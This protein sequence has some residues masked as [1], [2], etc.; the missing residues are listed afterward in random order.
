MVKTAGSTTYWYDADDPM[1]VTARVES[2]LFDAFLLIVSVGL[3]SAWAL[4][5]AGKPRFAQ[6]QWRSILY[7]GGLIAASLAMACFGGFLMHSRLLGG[8]GNNFRP[9]IIWVRIG[10]WLSILAL[11]SIGFGKGRR[12]VVGFVCALATAI[13]WIAVGMAP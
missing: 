13:L 2:S 9:V 10:L 11:F 7:F 5:V 8:F 3:V 1:P 12:R 6:P 4:W